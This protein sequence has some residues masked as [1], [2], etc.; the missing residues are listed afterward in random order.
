VSDD[1]YAT[2]ADRDSF[3]FNVTYKPEWFKLTQVADAETGGGYDFDT[4]LLFKHENGSFWYAHDSGCS[5]PTPFAGF[6]FGDG[7][8]RL[9]TLDDLEDALRS[10]GPDN[11]GV[12]DGLDMLRAAREAGLL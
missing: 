11:L 8:R 2:D 3:E 4:A 12:A 7:L 5:C 10:D 6:T 1:M 9:N